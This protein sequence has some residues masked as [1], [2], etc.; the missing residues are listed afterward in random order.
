MIL[1]NPP[2]LHET[3]VVGK[4]L[5]VVP[6]FLSHQYS[7]DLVVQEDITKIFL[8]WF[9]KLIVASNVRVCIQE[10]L[11]T[12]YDNYL[13]FTCD[14]HNFFIYPLATN[15]KVDANIPFCITEKDVLEG[16]IEYPTN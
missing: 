5:F 3:Y 13:D 7:K 4:K 2:P 6:Y 9:R 16:V 8:K 12:S 11:L 1:W 15:D 10:H 14:F